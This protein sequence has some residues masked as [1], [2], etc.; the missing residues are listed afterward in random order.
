MIFKSQAT[1]CGVVQIKQFAESEHI[2]FKTAQ[3]LM[4]RGI[5]TAQKFQKF[6]SPKLDD[7]RD[8]FLLDQMDKCTNRIKLA[9]KN[10]ESIL[11]FGD[12]D[13]DGISA[14]T[15]LYKYLKDKVKNLNYFLPNRYEDGY[16]LT[17][18]TSKKVIEEFKPQLIITV[19]CGISCFK[20]VDYI[21]S[22]GIDIIITDHHEIPETI[23][24]TI[25]VD[26]KKQ[27][28]Q[29]GFDGLCGAGVA[30]KIVEALV[31]RTNINDYLPICAIAT[32][33]D[34]VPLVDENRAIVKLGLAKQNELPQGIKMLAESLKIKVIN[35]SAI[36]FKI[37]P[38]LNAAGRMGNAYTALQLYIASDKKV[39]NDSLTT[40]A[41]QN[42]QRQKLSQQIYDECLEIIK[43][44]R[45]YNN[46]AIILKSDHW[47]SGLLGIACARLVDDFF[48][49]VFL[50]S[51]DKDILKGSVRSIDEINIHT[52]LSN[53]QSTLETF[54]GHSMAAGLSL[55]T[56]KFGMF[57]SQIFDYLNKNTTEKNYLPIKNYDVLV[58]PEDVTINFAKELQLLEP[59]GC[60]NSNPLF[61]IE[62]KDCYV[63]K[64][65]N[66]DSH[67]NISLKNNIKFIAFNASEYIDDY[68][69]A[70]KKQTIFELQI[71]EF[72][73]KEYLKG[74]V[75]STL[76]SGFSNSLQK[77][78]S[79]RQLKQLYF[80]MPSTKQF[81]NFT[82]ESA[83][84]IFDKLL[85]NQS[86]TAIIINDIETY[87]KLSNL[88]LNYKL[89]Y[90]VGG[91]QSKFE[92]NCIIFALD[93]IENIKA[94]QNLVFCDSIMTKGYIDSF[95]GDVYIMQAKSY[96]LE[97]I[98]LD[99]AYFGTVFLA[100][101]KLIKNNCSVRSD[102]DTFIEITRANPNLS[103]MTFSQFIACFYTFVQIG[104]IKVDKQFGYTIYVDENVKSKLENSSFYNKL[105]L[106]MKI[107]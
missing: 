84:S 92:E 37:A 28:Q 41:E 49:P 1:N 104:V 69:F 51:E 62:Y 27:N 53:C 81:Y 12:Y 96:K 3:I 107:K 105:K 32:V 11:L 2:C 60:D 52:V 106:V 54:G 50:F 14:V 43:I 89:N 87:K 70:E 33:S 8:P 59:F 42:T 72:K 6:V 75:K 86:G 17:I 44:D 30:L 29:Y 63:S 97:T 88:L 20:E 93:E 46:R 45:L 31:G 26:P 34:I 16:G 10:D 7:L 15:I 21:K 5:D 61:L 76:F 74:I 73:G 90:Y 36:S 79:A 38:R 24:N 9:I 91:S 39:L 94:Y 71:N 95:G 103:K 67:I 64:M 83:K 66:F 68:K 25:V 47:D 55:K 100:I 40:L 48:R 77:I 4:Q 57:K 58:K 13:V 98:N 99:R 56:E 65:A 85:Q 80:D 35:S 82:F 19:D 78:A 18:D 101:K 22:Q 102:L 23:P